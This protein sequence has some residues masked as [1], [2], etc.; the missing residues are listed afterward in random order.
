MKGRSV[1]CTICF[2]GMPDPSWRKKYQ[3]GDPKKNFWKFFS[4]IK[5]FHLI[6][7][8]HVPIMLVK[9]FT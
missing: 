1:G 2:I 7:E 4:K 8:R 3:R 5:E 6:Y 9:F